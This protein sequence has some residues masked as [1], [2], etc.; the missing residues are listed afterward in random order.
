MNK[1]ISRKRVSSAH[2]CISYHGLRRYSTT[3]LI[4]HL[5]DRFPFLCL[6]DYL[7]KKTLLEYGE[8]VM[9]TYIALIYLS[10]SQHT[11]SSRPLSM[12]VRYDRSGALN[13]TRITDTHGKHNCGHSGYASDE[14]YGSTN[15]HLLGDYEK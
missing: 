11:P 14:I 4:I 9:S 15:I 1:K 8:I 7:S 12:L 3:R 6:R 5:S 2:P 10:N 13:S